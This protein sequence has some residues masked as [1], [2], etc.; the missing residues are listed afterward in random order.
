MEIQ[1]QQEPQSIQIKMIFS[2][3]NY[4]KMKTNIE[5]KIESNPKKE[6]NFNFQKEITVRSEKQMFNMYNIMTSQVSCGSCHGYE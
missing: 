6:N 2:N 5:K 4:N 1:K 3:F